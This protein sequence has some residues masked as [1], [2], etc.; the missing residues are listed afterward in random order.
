MHVG[1]VADYRLD[2]RGSI[3]FRGIRIFLLASVPRPALRPTQ[4][5][6]KSELEVFSRGQIAAVA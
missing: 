6:I 3:P 2:D 1:V 4:S 5:R